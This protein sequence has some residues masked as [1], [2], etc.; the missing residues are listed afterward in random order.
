MNPNKESSG[1]RTVEELTNE[2]QTEPQCF[3]L[4]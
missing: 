3:L 2:V 1:N 4:R